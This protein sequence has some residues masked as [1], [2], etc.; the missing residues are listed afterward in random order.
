MRCRFL[1][2]SPEPPAS[3]WRHRLWFLFFVIFFPQPLLAGDDAAAL[4]LQ[5]ER[6]ATISTRTATW[7][8]LD[9]DPTGSTLVL[10]VLGD[11]YSLPVSGGTATRLTDGLAFDSQPRFSPDG[12]RIVFISDRGGFDELWTIAPDGSDPHRIAKGS[13]QHDLASPAW[14]PDGQHVVVSRQSWGLRTFE[15]WAYPVNGGTGVQLT[16]AS[17]K[18]GTPARDRGNS[19]GPVYS[20]DGQYLYY[21]RKRGGFAYNVRFPLWQIARHDLRSD[22]MTVIS[23]LPGSAFKPTLSPDGER[24]AYATRD[25]QATVLR[26]RNLKTGEDRRYAVPLEDDEQESRYTRDLLPNFAFHPNGDS[27]FLSSKGRPV[28]LNLEDGTLRAIPFQVEATVELGALSRHSYRLGEGPVRARALM[29][30]DL[31]PDGGALVF[32]AFRRIYRYDLASESL[33]ALTREDQSAFYP[34]FSPDGRTVAY[35]TW[36]ID[37]GHVFSIGAEGGRPRRLTRDAGHYQELAYSPDG[38]RLVTLKGSRF[39]RRTRE[40]DG[41]PTVDADLVWL[42]ARGGPLTRIWPATGVSNLHFVG[43]DSDRIFFNVGNSN[44]ARSEAGGLTSIRFDGTDLRNELSVI[45]PGIYSAEGDVQIGAIRLAPDGKTLALLHADQLYLAQRLNPFLANQKLKLTAAQLPV[46]RLTN[47]GAHYAFFDRAGDHVYW[48]VGSTLH[49]RSLDSIQWIPAANDAAT[50]DETAA[51]TA[52]A[53][54]DSGSEVPSAAVASDDAPAPIDFTS[55]EP[56]EAHEAVEQ[57]K[58]DV[59]RPRAEPAGRLALVGGTALPMTGRADAVVIED[60][61]VLVNGSRI[62]AVGT[63]DSVTV[64][65]D[66]RV[67]DVTGKTIMPGFIDAHAHFRPY[68]DLHATSDW[69][70]LANLAIGVT[71]GLD[72]QPSTTDILAYEEA[73]DAGLMLGPRT[74]STGP[75][76]FSNN[77]FAKPE[78]AYFVLKRYR[79]HYGV[80]NLKAYISGDRKQRQ[81]LVQ[82]ARELKLN[83]TT[84]GALDMKLGLT[85]A[86][87]GFSGNEHNFPLQVLYDDVVQLLAASQMSSVPTLL[88]LYGGPWGEEHFYSRENPIDNERLRRFTPRKFLERRALRRPIWVSDAEERFQQVASQ[89]LKLAR[90]GVPVGIGAHGQLQGLGYHWELWA[91][92]SGGFEPIEAL[93]AAT[94]EGARIIGVESS[95]GSIEPGKLADLVVLNR[96]PLADLRATAEVDRVMRGGFLYRGETLDRQWPEPAPLPEQW[97][98]R[99]D[100]Q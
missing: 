29:Q 54:A 18:K 70:L 5:P 100:S 6:T 9:V 84:E 21:A 8:N 75:G 76:I 72:V 11:L 2:R 43:G 47:I 74:L 55:F 66:A 10:D 98:Q 51:D 85:H 27:L 99:T 12:N 33:K 39:E 20:P 1:Q 13:S 37:G 48:M 68:K 30:P 52:E 97:W 65:E 40:Y 26:L 19:L 42:P 82:A 60:S 44:F 56:F 59:Y 61:V 87:D 17:P 50:A 45:G 14:S 67:I 91:V 38:R 93:R 83:P 64:P 95:I 25:Q 34:R 36:D 49:R 80:R 79:D 69:S 32:S 7:M 28:Q 53:T 73:T 22:R 24:L 92:A 58:V 96:N 63:R 35:L 90:A 88:V 62:E 16:K 57:W 78:E 4:S 3:A 71:T 77:S 94:I 15:L 23:A 89:A 31:S 41:G 81:W 46:I 86:L